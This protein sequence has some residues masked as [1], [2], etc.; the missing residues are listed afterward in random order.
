MQTSISSQPQQS[1]QNN[2]NQNIIIKLHY[3]NVRGTCQPL[4]NLLYYLDAP[5]VFIE[6]DKTPE[7]L[8]DVGFNIGI[9]YIEDGDLRLH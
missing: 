6:E 4:I 8:A 5:F 1:E 3:F 7:N 2:T 9:P